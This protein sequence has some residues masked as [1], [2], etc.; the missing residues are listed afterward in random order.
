LLVQERVDILARN[1]QGVKGW[2]EGRE[3][4]GKKAAE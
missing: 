1:M 2:K 4:D 3:P